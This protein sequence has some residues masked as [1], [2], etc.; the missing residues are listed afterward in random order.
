MAGLVLQRQ[1]IEAEILGHCLG[2]NG[3]PKKTKQ[4]ML[5]IMF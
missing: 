1:D 5:S 4:T 3:K 2:H